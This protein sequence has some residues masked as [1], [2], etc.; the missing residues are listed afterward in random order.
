MAML[1]ICM[2]NKAIWR[3]VVDDFLEVAAMKLMMWDL[4][5][6]KDLRTPWCHVSAFFTIGYVKMV[7]TFNCDYIVK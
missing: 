1:K 5:N 6:L 3:R 4:S 7:E 2:V